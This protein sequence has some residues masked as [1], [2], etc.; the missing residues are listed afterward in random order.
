MNHEHFISAYR[1]GRVRVSVD[2]SRA[3]KVCES[4]LM[5]TRYRAAHR[6][7]G[8][9]MMLLILGGLVS[10]FWVPWWVGLGAALVGIIMAPAIQKSA[11]QFVLEHALDN[12]SFYEQMVAAGVVVPKET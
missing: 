3:V 8:W 9:I 2:R 6:L 4:S 11:C 7:W 5:P 12:A 1:S 10:L